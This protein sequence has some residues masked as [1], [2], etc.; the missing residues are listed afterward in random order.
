MR[1]P[2]LRF[3]LLGWGHLQGKEAQL[4]AASHHFPAPHPPHI[5]LC[6]WKSLPISALFRNRE[7]P[8]VPALTP[9]ALLDGVV[10]AG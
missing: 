4:T 3:A 8:N 2:A 6:P 5:P 10:R 7:V 1:T 9:F